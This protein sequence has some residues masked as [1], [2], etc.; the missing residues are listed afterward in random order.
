MLAK[1]GLQSDYDHS[2]LNVVAYN[3]TLGH[4]FM[5]ALAATAAIAGPII[6]GI[7]NAPLSQAQSLDGSQSA[8]FEVS[9]IKPSAVWRSG[10]ERRSRSRIEH[11]P[12]S[13]TMWNVDLSDCVEWAYGVK[14]YQI[15]RPTPLGDERYVILAKAAGP[16][17]VNELRIMLR[18][19]L[20]KRFKL[21]LHRETKLLPVYELIVA[22]HGP[23]LPAPK[24][25]GELASY[26][27]VE[28]LPRVENGSFV[29]QE[30]SITEFTE[31]L[32]LLRGI[33]RPVLDRTE[34]QGFY[35]ITLRSAA[36]AILAQVRHGTVDS[37]MFEAS[38]RSK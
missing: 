12:D 20:A 16:A 23:K 14:F 18:D 34:I 19:L 28:S 2:R 25:G 1:L 13:L 30:T 33:E 24:P 10:G 5:L 17:P 35:D 38:D 37:R 9:S 29:L 4:R 31:N 11:S 32:S 21:A 36:S 26:H 7:E 15:S 27:A 3:L 8:A 22:K 6:I